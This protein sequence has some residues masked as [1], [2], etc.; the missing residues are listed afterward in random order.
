M[1]FLAF[2][3][4]CINMFID[5]LLSRE[6]ARTVFKCAGV[7][8]T[9]VHDTVSDNTF[10]DWPRVRSPV[11]LGGGTD[12][13]AHPPRKKDDATIMNR[14]NMMMKICPYSAFL[15]FRLNYSLKN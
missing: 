15:V 10:H 7:P 3:M 9:C 14:L 5:A 8:L 6:S 2:Q 1:I 13:A 4:H 11:K 12:Q